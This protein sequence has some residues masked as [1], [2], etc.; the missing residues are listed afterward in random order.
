MAQSNILKND[1]NSIIINPKNL[2][3]QLSKNNQ[4]I[5]PLVP[6]FRAKLSARKQV[7]PELE[8]FKKQTHAE[9]HGIDPYFFQSIKRKVMGY[10]LVFF[11]LALVFIILGFTASTLSLNMSLAF[12]FGATIEVK[13]IVSM[14]SFFLAFSTIVFAISLCSAKEA[15]NALI[16]RSLNNLHHQYKSHYIKQKGTLLTYF[17]DTFHKRSELK[18]LYHQVKD[19]IKEKGDKTVLLIKKIRE[20][21]Q[22]DGKKRNVLCCQA[23]TELNDKL[24]FILHSFRSFS[25][26]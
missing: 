23:L 26:Q 20:Y 3:V 16:Q 2:V 13:W 1:P 19:K 10:R 15:V 17:S 18:Q 5:T 22:F 21:P 9:T 14:L 25:D 7:Y 4:K 8:L 11:T 12:L 24:S 6:S